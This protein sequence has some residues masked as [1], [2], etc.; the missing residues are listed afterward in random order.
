MLAVE[1]PASAV[2][3]V[4]IWAA[5]LQVMAP[6]VAT[7]VAHRRQLVRMV[8]HVEHQLAPLDATLVELAPLTTTM[9]SFSLQ[10]MT[11]LELVVGWTMVLED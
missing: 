9:G 5:P 2:Y 3:L 7:M 10:E 8:A 6:L 1:E 4:A 11:G